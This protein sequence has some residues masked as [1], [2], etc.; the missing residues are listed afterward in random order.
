MNIIPLLMIL[1]FFGV[2]LLFI[3]SK[4]GIGSFEE[5]ATANRS[6]GAF[7]ITFSVLATYVVG[8]M[9]TSWAGMGVTYGFIALY[10]VS[11]ALIVMIVLFFVAPKTY[12]WGAK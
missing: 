7:A 1:L 10:N 12:I 11:Y 6:F 4:A 3:R 2:M 8:A 5:Y 9:Y